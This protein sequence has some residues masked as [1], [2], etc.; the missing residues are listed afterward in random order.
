MENKNYI[1]TKV[2]KARKHEEKAVFDE[3]SNKIINSA[4]RVHKKLGP[5][6]MESIYENALCVDLRKENIKFEQQ[7][8]IKIYYEGEEVGIHRIDLIIEDKIIVELKTVK[9]FED[10]HFAQVI[11]Y[12]KATGLQIGLL[13]NF[14]K[15]T[16]KIKRIVN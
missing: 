7:K 9:E 5:G 16:L 12:L 3:L 13:L 6:F 15:Y 1:T 8:G 14:A 2:V 11:S 10:I 4:I